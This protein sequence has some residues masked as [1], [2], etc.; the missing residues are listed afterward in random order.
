MTTD[1]TNIQNAYMMIVRVAVRCP[2]ML[3]ISLIMAFTINV[4]IS[5]I[6]MA[7]IPVLGVGLFIIFK[8]VEPIFNRV[9]NKYDA[10][11]N[12]IQENVKGMRVVKSYVREDYEIE[13]FD[14]TAQDVRADFTLGE[15]SSPSTPRSCSSASGRQSRSS[16]FSGLP[17]SCVRAKRN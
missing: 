2:V 7:L 4:K 10:M 5:A 17:L 3:V 9:F 1:V 11:N 8:K 12:S 15:K 14:K 13:K 16:A 6:F